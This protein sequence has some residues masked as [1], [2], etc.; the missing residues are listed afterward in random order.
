MPPARNNGQGR[1]PAIDPSS[2]ASADLQHRLR[3][4][5]G[6]HVTQWSGM[7]GGRNN[8]LFHLTTSGGPPLV[9][10]F[11]HR[12]RW[13]RLGHEF[14]TLA[15]LGHVGASKVP[16]A[17]VCSAAFA[18]G[19]YSFEPGSPRPAA[20]LR[21]SELVAAARLAAHLHTIAP[22]SARAREL[23]RAIGAALSVAE[24]VQVIDDRLRDFE[25][26][27]A[28]P[29]ADDELRAACRELD[30]RATLADLVAR[31][32]SGLTPDQSAVPLPPSSWRLNT[33]DFGPHNLL[34]TEAGQVTA[35][36]FE[37][38]GWDD[39]ARLVMGFVAHAA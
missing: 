39:P 5:F 3:A 10:K 13:D 6:Q 22:A 8:R 27:A 9:A 35:V 14:G 4:Q 15:F 1:R 31:A 34:V 20:D 32:T 16:R 21:D 30:L 23:P 28:S 18:Y 36:D 11:Y 24:H 7:A 29:S 12:D 17:Y 33:T 2:A 19:V 25:T 38:A 37:G 26:F